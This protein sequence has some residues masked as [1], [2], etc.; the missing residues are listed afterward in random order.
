L[1]QFSGIL[2]PSDPSSSNYALKILSTISPGALDTAIQ[3]TRPFFASLTTPVNK[4]EAVCNAAGPTCGARQNISPAGYGGYPGMPPQSYPPQHYYP[5]TFY[6]YQPNYVYQQQGP[7]PPSAG[8]GVNPTV[9][10]N[11][12][13]NQYGPNPW[14]A[15]PYGSPWVH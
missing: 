5:Q 2:D 1:A 7:P 9:L 10:L 6:G 14:G 8:G 12:G 13:M 4:A 11:N 15:N 3:T